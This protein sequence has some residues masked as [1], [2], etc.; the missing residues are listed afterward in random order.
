MLFFAHNIHIGYVTIIQR[1]TAIATTTKTTAESNTV[2][3]K[4]LGL[5]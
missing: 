3:H 2:T 4:A 5:S 1:N